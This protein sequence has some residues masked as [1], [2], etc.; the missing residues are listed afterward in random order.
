MNDPWLL[1]G[2]P[3]DADD[4]TIRRAWLDAVRRYPPER[5]PA[6]FQAVR[7][8]FERIDTRRHRLAHVLFEAEPPNLDTLIALALSNARDESERK[9][10]QD[11][12][13]ARPTP[14]VLRRLLG[15]SERAM[16]EQ[17]VTKEQRTIN[18][19]RAADKP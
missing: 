12:Q 8:A 7:A 5:D 2:V 10:Q 3:R 11:A 14:E 6:R 18:E 1:L 13:S 16:N 17:P 4:E 19:Q 15:E 9:P